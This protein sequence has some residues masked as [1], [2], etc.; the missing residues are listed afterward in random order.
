ML[1]VNTSDDLPRNT[2][3]IPR[4][5]LIEKLDKGLSRKLTLISAAAGFGKTTLLCS[6]LHRLRRPFAYVSFDERDNDPVRFWNHIITALQTTVDPHIGKRAQ[7]ILQT[8]QAS[9]LDTMVVTLIDEIM[10]YTASTTLPSNQNAEHA[11]ILAFDDYQLIESEPLHE[12]LNFFIDRMPPMLHLVIATRADP[13]LALARRRARQEMIEIRGAELRFTAEETDEFLNKAM[14]LGLQ[15]DEVNFLEQRTE[16]WIVSLQLAALSL[17]THED[18]AGFIRTFAGDDRYVVDYLVDEVLTKQ[19]EEVQEFLLRTA[20]LERLCGPLCEALVRQDEDLRGTGNGQRMLEY[21]ERA[22]LFIIPLDNKRIWYRYHHLFRDMLRYRLQQSRSDQIPE[23][24]RRAATWLQ[25]ED[26]LEDALQQALAAGELQWAG[27]LLEAAGPRILWVRGEANTL[28]I[29]LERLPTALVRDNPKLCLLYVW[30]LYLSGRVDAAEPYLEAA[31]ALLK[32]NDTHALEHSTGATSTPPIDMTESAA[33]NE[34]HRHIMMGEV[35]AARALIAGMR[36]DLP[37]ASDSIAHAERALELLP[38]HAQE[39]HMR[40]LLTTGLAEAY[41]LHGDINAAEKKFIEA[42]NMAREANSLFL[43]L[44]SMAR[45]AGVQ[46]IQGRLHQAASTCKFL[47]QQAD[48]WGAHPMTAL[49]KIQTA[50]LL[51]EWNDLDAAARDARTAGQVIEYSRKTAHARFLMESYIALA[52]VLEAQGNTRDALDTIEEAVRVEQLHKVVKST[53]L[54]SATAYQAR[55]WLAKGNVAAAARWAQTQGL[56]S[57]DR[58]SYPRELEYLTLARLLVAQGQAA[59]AIEL[60]GRLRQAAEAGGRMGHV[61]E[62]LVV[63]ALAHQAQGNDPSALETLGEALTLA[64][65]EGYIRVF[66]DEGEPMARLLGQAA[67]QGIVPEYCRRLLAAFPDHALVDAAT[68]TPGHPAPELAHPLTQRELEVLHL[69]MQGLAN[70][71]IA[72][73]LFLSPDTVKVHSRNIYGKL[74]VRSRT[75][76]VAKAQTLGLL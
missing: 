27:R 20:V 55:L 64:A 8:L 67:A 11:F 69:I 17:Q 26:L 13:P 21:L 39:P 38:D 42:G 53:S 41:Y 70:K 5:R 74:G 6:E 24:H 48:E 7:S 73:R 40:C 12:S 37:R 59:E 30:A 34:I 51:R 29:N 35:A 4:S 63:Q 68:T 50:S 18:R 52:R 3:V 9:S 31:E 54:P 58:L 62:M 43:A 25:Q 22:N 28:L 2:N 23:L 36:G 61:I 45:L 71:E 47:Q 72:R 32:T 19:S 76:A 49:A 15:P 44:G 57:T 56:R 1:L 75:Q 66:L 65:A 10:T 33:A 46:V 14:G 16:G 60:L